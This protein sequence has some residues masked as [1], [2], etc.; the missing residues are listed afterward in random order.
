MSSHLID[1]H[2]RLQ[3]PAPLARGFAGRRLQPVSATDRHLL[4]GID[5]GQG[6][7]AL[8][9]SLGDV[10][11]ADLLS[12]LNMFRKTGVLTIRLA[13][14]DKNLYF[15]N[16][17]I[18]FATST[19]P[20]EDL[21]EVLCN[22]GKISRELLVKARQ[23]GA[24]G[25]S[26]S[27]G[28]QLVERGTISAKD[29]WLAT[30]QQV[31]LIVYQLFNVQEGAFAFS[32]R[33]L[34]EEEIVRLSMNTQNLIMEGVQR[35]DEQ[36]LFLRRIGSLDLRIVPEDVVPVELSGAEQELVAIV[37][38]QQCDVRALLRLSGLGE[39][40]TLQMVY[41]LL[42]KRAIHLEEVPEVAM[43]GELGEMLTVC[44]AALMAIHRRV[45]AVNPGFVE[46]V[47]LF[48]RD[49]PQPFSYVLRDVRLRQDGSVDGGRILANLAGL[50]GA[51]KLKLLADALNELIFMGC[52][53][54]RRDLREGEAA[55]LVA[56]V[57]EVSGRIKN[58]VGRIG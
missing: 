13:G 29:L 1:S 6:A 56:R 39:F 48:L 54:A 4:L 23:F 11:M 21:G 10:S 2:G 30:R 53:A 25:R 7:P 43:S 38:A 44:N 17:E 19:F 32:A 45:A 5:D 20:E 49:L 26:V 9:G 12:F 50:E 16:G 36:E 27:L 8:A 37:A 31:E 28:R 3:L 22:F 35:V 41:Q 33:P 34:A 51:D 52:M 18:V 40:A 57:Q 58:L 15:H 14:G 24:A 47:R 46:E 42:E 55:E